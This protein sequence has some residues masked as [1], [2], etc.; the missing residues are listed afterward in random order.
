MIA[1]LAVLGLP[2]AAHAAWPGREGRIA[3]VVEPPAEATHDF[4]S[5]VVTVR[6]NGTDPVV[7]R[8]CDYETTTEPCLPGGR[9]PLAWSRDGRRLAVSWG[10]RIAVVNADGSGWRFITS[11]ANRNWYPSW[12]PDGRW[13]AM[14]RYDEG[15]KAQDLYLVRADGSGER[16]L[17]RRA[18]VWDTAWSARGELAY[19][20]R[21][22]VSVT[23]A[24]G[25]RHRVLV[26]NPVGAEGLDWAPNGGRL[27]LTRPGELSSLRGWSVNRT[28]RLRREPRVLT[29]AFWSPTGRRLA[30]SSTRGFDLRRA[31]G[32]LR[33]SV[34]AD[35]AQWGLPDAHAWQAVPRR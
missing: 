13:I 21:R 16:R 6:P 33:R 27:L 30:V 11:G 2:A 23:N 25:R 8:V 28:G 31:N 5:R 14:A 32:S 4:E 3:M 15:T 24:R 17:T 7:V 29:G 26:R 35:V 12:S 10:G 34:E 22:G 20:S 19:V 18:G 1:S 9:R